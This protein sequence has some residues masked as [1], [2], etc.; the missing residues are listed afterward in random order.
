[1]E[2]HIST[3]AISMATTTGASW[4]GNGNGYLVAVA[5]AFI[6]KETFRAISSII[7]SSR[8]GGKV[9]A[10]E[11]IENVGTIIMVNSAAAW[12]LNFVMNRSVF[13]GAT[14]VIVAV[15]LAR[16]FTKIFNTLQFIN[17]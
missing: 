7:S 6:G 5:V 13:D 9:S 8:T 16:G 10:T 3:V 2:W 11:T 15:V 14:I 12:L 17:S 1:M 4:M